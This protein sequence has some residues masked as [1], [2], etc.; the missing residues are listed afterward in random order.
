MKV[1]SPLLTFLRK[2]NI[3][4]EKLIIDGTNVRV[5]TVEEVTVTE[6]IPFEIEYVYDEELWVVQKEITTP[7]KDGKKEIVYHIT[8]ENGV[9]LH[10]TK[11][12]KQLLRNL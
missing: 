3:E 11:I 7:G 9:E 2:L 12:K 4:D 10:R 5:T 6:A 8:R 1:Q